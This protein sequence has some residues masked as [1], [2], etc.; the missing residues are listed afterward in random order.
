MNRLT[1]E[2]FEEI[3]DEVT[4]WF[5]NSS[6]VERIEFAENGPD[7]YHHGVGTNIRNHFKLWELDWKPELDSDGV[8]VSPDHP[9]N[10]SGSILEAVWERVNGTKGKR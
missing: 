3:V 4:K 10:I 1:E 2:R 8:D 9:D 5:H 7:V 6:E